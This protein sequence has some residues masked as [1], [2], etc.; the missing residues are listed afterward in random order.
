MTMECL[1]LCRDSVDFRVR[2]LV[3]RELITGCDPSDVTWWQ[4]CCLEVGVAVESSNTGVDWFRGVCLV[5][6]RN[7]RVGDN[8]DG[9]LRGR[10][11]CIGGHGGARVRYRW[12]ASGTDVSRGSMSVAR[13][14]I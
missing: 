13:L 9:Y 11:L 7:I 6:S 14:T 2:A 3:V 10:G 12:L 4:G 5:D 8:G 1:A